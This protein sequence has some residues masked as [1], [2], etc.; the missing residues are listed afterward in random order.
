MIFHARNLAFIPVVVGVALAGHCELHSPAGRPGNSRLLLGV[1]G[2]PARRLPTFG[3]RRA[4]SG[5]GRSVEPEMNFEFIRQCRDS[6]NTV[7]AAGAGERATVE[8]RDAA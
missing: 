8:F 4:F 7:R 1:V 3:T 2:F 5:P 6:A